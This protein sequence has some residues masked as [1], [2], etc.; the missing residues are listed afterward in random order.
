MNGWKKDQDFVGA[1]R[2]LLYKV[3]GSSFAVEGSKMV[4]PKAKGVSQGSVEATGTA[5]KTRSDGVSLNTGQLGT[6]S[7]PEG[8]IWPTEFRRRHLACLFRVG[9]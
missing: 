5:G 9:G 7:G 1:G 3:A 4:I 6:W 8:G 2:R